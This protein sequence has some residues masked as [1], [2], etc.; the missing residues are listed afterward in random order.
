ME[1]TVLYSTRN[2]YKKPQ[3]NLQ[4]TKTVVNPE[5]RYSQKAGDVLDQENWATQI[6]QHVA[7]SYQMVV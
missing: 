1:P 6:G 7:I 4:H 2:I 3:Y 5:F